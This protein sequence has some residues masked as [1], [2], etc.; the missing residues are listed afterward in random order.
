MRYLSTRGQAPPVDF[1]GV[2]LGGLAPDG[3][4]Y[5]PET[6]PRWDAAQLR[7]WRGRPYAEVATAVMEPFV[8]PT[9]DHAALRTLVDAACA[10]FTHP[11]VAPV[12]PLRDGVWLLELFHGPTLAFKDVALQLLGRLFDVLLERRD[13]HGMVLGATSGDTGSAAIAGCRGRHAL[14]VV[15]LHPH[16]R[17]SEVQRRQMTTVLDDNVHNLAVEGTFDD[18]QAIVKALLGDPASAELRLVAVNSINWAR[19][20]AQIVY[21]VTA[22]LTLGAPDR[23]VRFVV[24]TGNF[25]DVFAGWCARRMGLPIAQ[26]VVATN[27]N[28][29]LARTLHTGAYTTRG[30][31]PTL[32]PSMDIQVSS[33]FERLLF[34]ASGR[35]GAQVAA[36]MAALR[37]DGGFTL[38]DATL[39]SIREVFAAARVDDAGT[40]EVMRRTHAETGMLVDPHTAVGLGA[41]EQL[42][43]VE[44]PT[45]VLAT[46]HPAKFPD[47]VAQATGVRPA[48]PPALADLLARTER[49]DVLPA[50]VD[51][52]RAA[53]W[54]H[55][56][57]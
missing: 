50:D 27:A 54:H 1:E 22:A 31:V 12:V 11:E 9:L 47:A 57:T 26:L 25:G 37:R 48:L 6:W 53:L 34:E 3:G 29:I 18:C 13:D 55:A 30:V 28:D 2:V 51:A 20:L 7:A 36:W 40:L 19:V 41:V 45:V 15:I 46:A 10:T 35:D 44:V 38:D 17:T 42:G 56:R 8:A 52:V 23:P 14:D 5:L 24:P 21:Y 39:A 49:F 4:L 32:S 43:P 16:G 33:N